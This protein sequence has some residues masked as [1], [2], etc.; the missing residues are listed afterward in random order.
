MDD[1][2]VYIHKVFT[3]VDKING[4]IAWEQNSKKKVFKVF[5]ATNKKTLLWKT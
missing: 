3:S 1:K 5:E 2:L 4:Q